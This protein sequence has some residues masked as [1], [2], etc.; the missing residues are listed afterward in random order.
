VGCSAILSFTLLGGMLGLWK[1]GDL[2]A[3][4]EH[5]R[6]P[7]R[8]VETRG[9]NKVLFNWITARQPRNKRAINFFNAQ[10]ASSSTRLT[11]V[12]LCVVC[13]SDLSFASSPPDT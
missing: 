12:M 5:S 7:D 9:Y 8:S 4:A 13:G 6:R 3:G 1:Q 2:H 11:A 10:A